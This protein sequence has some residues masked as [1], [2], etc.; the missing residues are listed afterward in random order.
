M[1]Y[2]V[3]A[4][5]GAADLIT[6]RGARLLREAE[7]VVYAGS[8]VNPELLE[9]CKPDCAIHDSS[10]MTL[11]QIVDVLV[12]ADAAGKLCVRLHTGDPALYGAHGEQME[13]LDARGIAYE[14]V[15]GVSSLFG[16]TAALRTELTVPEVSQT[17]IVTRMEGRTPM[18]EGERLRD[19]S[20]HGCTMAL[21]LSAGL[22]DRVQRE[23]LDGGYDPSTPTAIVVRATWPDEAVYRCTV[24]TLDA[25]AR[26]HNVTKTALVLVG[27]FLDACGARS[28]LYDAN[29]SHGYRDDVTCPHHLSGPKGSTPI[30]SGKAHRH[31]SGYPQG[32]D[33]TC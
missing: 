1:I 17:V 20:T 8:L 18:P 21:F 28:Q 4:G 33:A 7:V 26:E 24:A 15:P 27:A 11:E 16:A 22:L 31:L 2:F 5:P 9:L 13:E 6:V 10:R 32:N 19:L 3:G 25:C 30:G 14:V 12:A 23:L 29:F